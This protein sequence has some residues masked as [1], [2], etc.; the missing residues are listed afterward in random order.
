RIARTAT[1]YRRRWITS[2]RCR[3]AARTTATTWCWRAANATGFDGTTLGHRAI[4]HWRPVRRAA[5]NREATMTT[6]PYYS[7]DG[8]TLFHADCRD[9]LPGMDAVDLV[10]TDPPY[11]IGESRK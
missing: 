11:G 4:S 8:I 10:C 1:C 3:R 7:R 5:P 2:F 9:V 6:Q